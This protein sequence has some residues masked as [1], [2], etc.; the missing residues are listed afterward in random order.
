VLISPQAVMSVIGTEMDY[1]DDKLSS[2]FV[3]HNPNATA[4]CGCGES[5]TTGNT[6]A[7]PGATPNSGA[8]AQ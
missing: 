3:F 8:A 7:K 4:T 6:D 5:F 1:I 2:E